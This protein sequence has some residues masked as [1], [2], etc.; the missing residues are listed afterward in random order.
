[1]TGIWMT[2]Y[3]VRPKSMLSEFMT[4]GV[5]VGVA[6]AMTNP[7]GRLYFSDGHAGPLI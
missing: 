4:S 7:L 5:S 2:C 6:T 1:M 3:Q